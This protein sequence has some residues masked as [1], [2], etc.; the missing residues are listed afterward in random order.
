VAGLTFWTCNGSGGPAIGCWPGFIS[1]VCCFRNTP[2]GG[3]GR[4]RAPFGRRRNS[5]C[6]PM[7]GAGP[8]P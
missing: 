8:G 6:C 2:S 3:S 4:P 7:P 5:F 1:Q